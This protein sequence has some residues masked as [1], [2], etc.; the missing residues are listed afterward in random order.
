[1]GNKENSED[2]TLGSIDLVREVTEEEKEKYPIPEKDGEYF[3]T[4]VD[5]KGKKNFSKTDF[6]SALKEIG[7]VVEDR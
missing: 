5:V 6:I 3:K 4:I 2:W 1:M 7:G